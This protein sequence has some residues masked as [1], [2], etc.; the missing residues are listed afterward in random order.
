[1]VPVGSPDAAQPLTDGQCPQ[2][3]VRALAD[4]SQL[5]L[6]LVVREFCGAELLADRA[7]PVDA[8]SG[9]DRRDGNRWE[10]TGGS[11]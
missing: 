6:I 8:V 2:C 11:L 7:P 1:M 10:I 4:R 9:N 3:C 5:G